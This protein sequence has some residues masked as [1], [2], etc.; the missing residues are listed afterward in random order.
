M[1]FDCSATQPAANDLESASPSGKTPPARVFSRPLT[2][3]LL[4]WAF[5][6]VGL[7]LVLVIDY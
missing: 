4:V 5:M 7:G 6:F 1:L 2:F 3:V